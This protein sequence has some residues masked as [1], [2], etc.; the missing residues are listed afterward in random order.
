M[1]QQK[2]TTKAHTGATQKQMGN[3]A[4]KSDSNQLRNHIL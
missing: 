1:K 2:L 3:T 4:A